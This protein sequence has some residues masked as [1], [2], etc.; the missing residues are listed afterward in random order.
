M[1][2]D[3]ERPGQTE[4]IKKEL[5]ENHYLVKYRVGPNQTGIRLDQFLKDHYRKRSR[6]EIKR[7]IASE[8]VTVE[9]NQ[10]A[11]LT[12]G[13][14]K[15]ATLLL[16][17]DI[18]LVLSEKKP[19]PPVNFN[20][21]LIYEDDV[22][23]VVDK[24]ANLP[25]HPS[26]RF[27]F[28]TL[29]THLKIESMK[30]RNEENESH[31]SS[32]PHPRSASD[33]KFTKPK[34]PNQSVK[35]RNQRSS[36][37]KIN[38]PIID[39][40]DFFYLAHRI[41]KETSGILVLTKDSDSCAKIVEQFAKRQT[42]KKY[43]AI[44]K[45]NFQWSDLNAP[46][47][48][49]DHK[50]VEKKSLNE[51]EFTIDFAM[52]RDPKS[53]IALKMA[54]F[55]EKEGGLPSSTHFKVI[56]RRGDFSLLECSPKTGRQH[57]IRVHAEAAGYPLVGDKLYGV[58]EDFAMLFYERERLTPEAE[59]KLLLPRHALHSCELKFN[60]PIT[61]ERLHFKSELPEDLRN[62]FYR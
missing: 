54:C 41:D 57:Q 21:K 12:I 23:F 29:L 11:H 33:L 10:S 62:F 38:A 39:S 5:S 17:G 15:S 49:Y 47:F 59:A 52:N 19:E 22:L 1:R 28:N 36:L 27:F 4:Q 60:H 53:K 31:S 46:E 55:P 9:R 56:E 42:E 18:V 3:R 20:Y 40:E 51:T 50:V 44:V 14:L 37:A 34:E 48:T 8:A 45:N 7:A 30:R 35:E 24:P 6:E 32:L 26:G 13:K 25:V 16:E 61:G 2:R 58:E 43:L